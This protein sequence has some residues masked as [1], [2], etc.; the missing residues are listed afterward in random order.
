[1]AYQVDSACYSTAQQA[2]QASASQH[3]GAVV[4]HSGS[5]Y[6]VD[7]SAV[8]DTSITYRLQPVSGGTPLQ[9]VSG[10]TAQ[11]CNLLQVSDGLS[12]GWMV[13]G[14]WFGAYA[15]I[16]IARSLFTGE[17]RDGDT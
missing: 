8:A 5:A 12:M 4:S 11:P 1:M 15:L 10:Y 13:A 2:A 6:I 16:F 3:V 9:M 7:V 14:A 17:Q